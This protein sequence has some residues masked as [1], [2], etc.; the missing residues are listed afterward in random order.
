MPLWN[1]IVL[2]TKFLLFGFESASDYML[3]LLNE[4]ISTGNISERIQEIREYVSS[5]IFYMRKYQKYCPSIW[6]NDYAKL[7]VVIE[8]SNEVL[9]DNKITTDELE[10]VKKAIADIKAAIEEWMKD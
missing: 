7:L 1:R 10:K 5:L 8:T 4:F 9:A 2:G 6:E 3:K